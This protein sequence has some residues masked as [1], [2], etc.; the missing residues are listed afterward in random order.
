MILSICEC[1]CTLNCVLKNPMCFAKYSSFFLLG[2]FRQDSMTSYASAHR[3]EISVSL[4]GE[5]AAVSSA[6]ISNSTSKSTIYSQTTTDEFLIDCQQD[7]SLI[8]IRFRCLPST[9]NEA[10]L[11]INICQLSGKSASL[12]FLP[13]TAFTARIA[14]NAGSNNTRQQLLQGVVIAGSN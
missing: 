11:Q 2:P 10:A 9:Q 6:V 8:Q 7:K 5:A 12:I 1:T 4:S 13:M 14:I 3:W